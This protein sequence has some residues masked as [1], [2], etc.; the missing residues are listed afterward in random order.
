MRP[1]IGERVQRIEDPLLLRG[2]GRYTDDLN[3]PGQAYAYIVRS[4]HA[5]GILKRI[6]LEKA[7]SMSGVLAVYTAADLAAYG[8][9]K[10]NLGFK[11]RD[12]SA[13]RKPIRKAL[14]QD[15]GN[16]ADTTAEKLAGLARITPERVGEY[17]DRYS[18]A[19]RLGDGQ[20]AEIRT[21]HSAS[22]PT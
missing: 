9:H 3:E 18:G 8:P 20:D 13:M 2:E 17:V 11:Q 21:R 5:H 7:K 10:C 6:S 15:E 22:R 4:P 12:G 19:A 16:R 14:A 1:G